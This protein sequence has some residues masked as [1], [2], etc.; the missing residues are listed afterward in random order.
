MLLVRQRVDAA[1]YARGPVSWPAT[2]ATFKHNTARRG[3][4]LGSHCL[5]GTGLFQLSPNT[6]SAS[7]LTGVSHAPKGLAKDILDVVIIPVVFPKVVA[8]GARGATHVKRGRR[9]VGPSTS[10]LHLSILVRPL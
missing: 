3:Y 5:R 10:I 7:A 4:Q 9:R 2:T 6:S 8:A 1:R